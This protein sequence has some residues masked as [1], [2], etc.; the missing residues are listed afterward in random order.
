M[1]LEVAQCCVHIQ[2]SWLAVKLNV[3]A[4]AQLSACCLSRTLSTM[5]SKPTPAIIQCCYAHCAGYNVWHV[6]QQK[7]L[8]DNN[9]LE[10][11]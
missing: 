4:A 1:Q 8:Q 7:A 9:P 2:S 5:V 3:Y 11:A 6:P 10:P